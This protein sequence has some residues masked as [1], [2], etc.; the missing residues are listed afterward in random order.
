MWNLSEIWI[1]FELILSKNLVK[2]ELNFNEI[3]VTFD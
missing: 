2:I 3:S 1:T